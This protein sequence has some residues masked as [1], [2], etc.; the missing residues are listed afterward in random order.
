MR[1]IANNSHLRRR[2][3]VA[4]RIIRR[5]AEFCEF[6]PTGCRD[7]SMLRIIG[8]KAWVGVPLGIKKSPSLQV[9]TKDYR[10][11]LIDQKNQN[12]E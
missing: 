3:A 2:I 1:I 7:E 12:L 6:F 11:F 8:P 5:C 10:S 9:F 4:V